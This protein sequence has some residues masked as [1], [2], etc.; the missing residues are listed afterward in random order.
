MVKTGK[1]ILY[2]SRYDKFLNIIMIWGTVFT[3]VVFLSTDKK[4]EVF[5]KYFALASFILVSAA[6]GLTISRPC[7]QIYILI[8]F[9]FYTTRLHNIFCLL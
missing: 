4:P 7:N 9:I 2:K 1:G 8:K 3:Q 5:E 6:C